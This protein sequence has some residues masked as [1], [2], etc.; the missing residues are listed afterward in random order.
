MT[1]NEKDIEMLRSDPK[2]LILKY[3]ETIRIIVKKFISQ[4]LYNPTEFEDIVQDV[5]AILLSKIQTMQTHYNGMSLFRTYLSVIVRN[6]C[7]KESTKQKRKSLVVQ[8]VPE[9]IEVRATVD[10][11]MMIGHEVRKLKAILSLYRERKSKILLCLKLCFRIPLS[12]DDVFSWCE[13][14]EEHDCVMLLR[15]FGSNFEEMKDNEIY[16][17]VTPI[18]N[19]YE[20]KTNSPDAVRK[21]IDYKIH[22]IIDLLNGN[23][24]KRNHT[25][26]TLK[27]LIDDYFS[28]FLTPK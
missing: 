17:I 1:E 19:K 9:E 12:R 3:Q 24:K 23:S 20:A 27:I 16:R 28:P 26:E 13:R 11:T 22:E 2:G 7:L 15:H 10:E 21:W 6:I 18:F 4:G 5:N 14:C 25:A 8:E